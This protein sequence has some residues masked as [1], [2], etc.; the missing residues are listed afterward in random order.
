MIIDLL[1]IPL[2]QYAYS[3][4]IHLVGT[5]HSQGIKLYSPNNYD[6][7]VHEAWINY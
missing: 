4:G 5:T 1:G 6:N 2:S 3:R 7:Y